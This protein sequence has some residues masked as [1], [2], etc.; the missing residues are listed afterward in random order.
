MGEMI[1]PLVTKRDQLF[2]S[3][4]HE[5]SC[6]PPRHIL[7]VK[8]TITLSG[9]QPRV[10]KTEAKLPVL[11]PS[12]FF[13]DERGLRIEIIDLERRVVAAVL[14]KI[15]PLLAKTDIR[16]KFAVAD[17]KGRGRQFGLSRAH[18]HAGAD[19][20]G[21]IEKY[22]VGIIILD[23]GAAFDQ[24]TAAF[25]REDRLRPDVLRFAGIKFGRGFAGVIAQFRL[26]L[27]G[28]ALLHAFDL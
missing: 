23:I 20:G 14:E 18:H 9:Q 26:F 22:V 21:M 10:I 13:P 3:D 16:G 11:F 19:A 1:E 7:A 8:L 12:P 2:L 17:F 6:I 27:H 4:W 25:Y 5:I 28:T 24:G 15:V